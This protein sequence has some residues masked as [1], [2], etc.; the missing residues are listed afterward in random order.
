MK[1]LHKILFEQ[2]QG[3]S[4]NLS[5]DFNHYNQLLIISLCKV[6]Y[7]NYTEVHCFHLQKKKWWRGP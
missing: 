4:D 3:T 1:M 5:V 2:I 6:S 7:L